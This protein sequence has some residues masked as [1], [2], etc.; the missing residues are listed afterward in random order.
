MSSRLE[1]TSAT[2]PQLGRETRIPL[3]DFE[4]LARNHWGATQFPLMDHFLG[5]GTW[6]SA[7]WKRTPQNQ[8][9]LSDYLIFEGERLRRLLAKIIDELVGQLCTM[10]VQV[11][12]WRFAKRAPIASLTSP[13][14]SR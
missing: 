6:I 4:R 13:P 12:T 11:P 1:T 7:I 9:S 8:S 14:T 2:W 5:T 10:G 3:I